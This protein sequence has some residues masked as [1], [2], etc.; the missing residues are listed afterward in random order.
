MGLFTFIKEAGEK[1]FGGKDAHAASPTAPTPAEATSVMPN[2]TAVIF[3]SVL[4]I[5]R[6]L[7]FNAE[8][9]GFDI[10]V[11]QGHDRIHDQDRK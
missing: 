1:L 10:F 5:L 11:D 6:H 9:L 2:S 8:A 7:L 4:F 3:T